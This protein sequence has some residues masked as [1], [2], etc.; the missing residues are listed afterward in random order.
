MNTKIAAKLLLFFGLFVVAQSWQNAYDGDLNVDCGGTSALYRVRS[1][2]SNGAEDR[3]WQWEC[4]NVYTAFDHC[5]WTG[6][7]N[8]FDQPIY[9]KCNHDYVLAG[10][11]SY[12]DNGPEDRQWKAR[13]CK[14]SDHFVQDCRI[15]GH[16]NSY[17]SYMDFMVL[18]PEV[19]TGFFCAH[20]N[21]HE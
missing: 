2:H 12:H 7:L 19:F 1:E 11:H 15:T 17:D 20:D 5:Y 10:V 4:R 9:Y 14:S 6:Y 21:G 13:C 8:N 16:I 18:S 3:Q